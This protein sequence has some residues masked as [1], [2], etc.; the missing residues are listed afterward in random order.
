[1]IPR[2]EEL[3]VLVIPSREVGGLYSVLRIE[4]SGRATVPDFQTPFQ[5]DETI[6]YCGASELPLSYCSL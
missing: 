3:R 4:G 6:G 5:S 1:M 2:A